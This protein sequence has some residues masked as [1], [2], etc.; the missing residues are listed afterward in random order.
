MTGFKHKTP[1]SIA[2]SMACFYI[3][4]PGFRSWR[5]EDMVRM[6]LLCNGF[7]EYRCPKTIPGHGKLSPIVGLNH[8]L[9]QGDPITLKM[10]R[11]I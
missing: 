6:K 5:N 2:G 3:T 7:G 11:Q 1:L 9:F 4:L 8:K 10:I